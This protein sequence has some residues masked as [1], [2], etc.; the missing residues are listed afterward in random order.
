MFQ[1]KMIINR[2]KVVTLEQATKAQGGGLE[3]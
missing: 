2:H 1:M 3:V